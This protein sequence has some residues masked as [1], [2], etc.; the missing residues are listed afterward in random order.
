[1]MKMNANEVIES[2]VTDVAVALP[3]KQRN[4]VAFE[5][6]AL[7]SE[8]L[9]DKAEATGRPVDA[10]MA[11][12]FCRAFGKPEDVAA[13]YRP[14]L[15]IIDPA[16]GYAFMRAS[17]IGMVIL[18]CLLMLKTFSYPNEP[19]VAFLSILGHW[20][21]QTVNASIWWLGLLVAG[22]G[23]ASWSRRRSPQISQWKP[24]AR[25]RI[26][27]GR[28]GLV[29]G[30][31][32]ILFGAFILLEPTRILDF[33]WN[34]RAAPAAYAAL[35]YT[36]TFLGRQA[37]ILFA[38]IL[39]NVPIMV[40]AIVQGR[41]PAGMRRVETIFALITCAAMVWAVLDGPI[42][43][44]SVSDRTAKFFLMFIVVITLIDLGIKLLR[45]VNPTPATSS[46]G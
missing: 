22:F 26:V 19:S 42:L 3:R 10:E 37:P 18:S 8:G 43:M 17:I 46:A 41:W 16:D 29:F 24:S 13:R 9:Q 4:D 25:D 23:M 36:D 12:E 2:Y 39:L 31:I 21:A 44:T 34:G 20:W 32:G 14:T 35:T 45:R 27:G 1:M 15:T 40:F 38:L 6:R 7:I 11:I 33:F 5:L 30:I 28:T